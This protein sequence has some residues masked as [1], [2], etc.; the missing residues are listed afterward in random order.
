MFSA[1]GRYPFK[2]PMQSCVYRRS[3]LVCIFIKN[4]CNGKK[5]TV[6]CLSTSLD[7]ENCVVAA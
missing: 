2:A 4:D 3:A 7:A 5:N 1:I 6:S